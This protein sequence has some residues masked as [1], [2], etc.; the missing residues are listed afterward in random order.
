[1]AFRDDIEALEARHAALNAEATKLVR[2]RDAAASL[3]ADARARAKLPVLENIR[4]ASPCKANWNEMTG[5]ERVRHCGKCDKQVFDLS[6]M[7]RVE[8]EAL[9]VEKAGNLC[10]R[11]YQRPDG[12]I[13]LADCTVGIAN[14]RKLRVIAAGAAALLAGGGAAAYKATRSVPVQMLGGVESP[15][16]EDVDHADTETPSES[17]HVE[18]MMGQMMLLPDHDQAR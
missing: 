7:T 12:T 6:E 14:K 2:E 1:M 4:I 8:A 9:I 11:Y 17:P 18:K 15:V 3:L 16:H 10:A 13:L 5:D